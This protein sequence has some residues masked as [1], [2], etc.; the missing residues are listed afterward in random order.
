MLLY[1]IEEPKIENKSGDYSYMLNL[2]K[3]DYRNYFKASEYLKNRYDFCIEA[4]YSCLSTVNHM[5]N[6]KIAYEVLSRF[7][8]D[9]KKINGANF[10]IVDKGS[11]FVKEKPKVKVKRLITF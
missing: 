11:F 2:I 8:N 3:E 1:K 10:E 7:L 4:I 5:S 6:R 9:V